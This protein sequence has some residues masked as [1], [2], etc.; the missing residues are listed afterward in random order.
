MKSVRALKLPHRGLGISAE[1]AIF[2]GTQQVQVGKHALQ[3]ADIG[4]IVTEP[5]RSSSVLV[6]W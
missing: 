1:V 6:R 5:Q 4:A 2:L 3:A